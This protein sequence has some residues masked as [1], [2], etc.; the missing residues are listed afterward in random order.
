MLAINCCYL[1][2]TEN[3]AEKQQSLELQFCEMVQTTAHA[4]H[5]FLCWVAF[6]LQREVLQH[7]HLY[8]QLL[9]RHLYSKNWLIIQILQDRL[10]ITPRWS[11][12]KKGEKPCLN[13]AFF[14]IEYIFNICH[15]IQSH[16]MLFWTRTNST[17]ELGKNTRYLRWLQIYFRYTL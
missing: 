13:K 7:W 5:Y 2:L 11:N 10:K 6:D 3:R 15:K 4:E 14:Q 1:P 9:C 17:S 16:N 12:S 8:C